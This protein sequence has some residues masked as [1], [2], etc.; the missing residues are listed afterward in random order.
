MLNELDKEYK[1]AK[2]SAGTDGSTDK[3]SGSSDWSGPD[4]DWN[5]GGEWD[6]F[7]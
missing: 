6:D 3:T 1:E 7:W 5:A 2:A 4:D